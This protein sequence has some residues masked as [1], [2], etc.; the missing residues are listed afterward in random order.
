[1]LLWDWTLKT[2]QISQYRMCEGLW[3]G[4]WCGLKVVGWREGWFLDGECLLDSELVS[5]L[6]YRVCCGAGAA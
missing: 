1:M 2:N 5:G 3:G 4:C 6:H